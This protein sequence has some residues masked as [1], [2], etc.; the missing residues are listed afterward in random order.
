MNWNQTKKKSFVRRHFELHCFLLFG[1]IAI[2]CLKCFQNYF[3]TEPAWWPSTYFELWTHY[4]HTDTTVK[5]R[6]IHCKL[7]YVSSLLI[8][9]YNV[10]GLL[11]CGKT[12]LLSCIWKCVHVL[13]LLIYAPCGISLTDEISLTSLV[14]R[15]LFSNILVWARV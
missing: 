11:R 15:R 13:A 2:I 7:L 10:L 14:A 3:S 12:C 9:L 8:Y 5:N 6:Y 4:T 1:S